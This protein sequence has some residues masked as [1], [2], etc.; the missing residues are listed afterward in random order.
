MTHR[1]LYRDSACSCS[2]TP[3]TS[4]PAF[5]SAAPSRSY[6]EAVKAAQT[7]ESNY[8]LLFD[9]IRAMSRLC[10]LRARHLQWVLDELYA[11]REATGEPHDSMFETAR[12]LSEVNLDARLIALPRRN[13]ASSR[14]TP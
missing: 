1:P 11:L 6:Q 4:S 7:W 3:A 12:H 14:T 13:H 8:R 10:H 5:S 9:R 2:L